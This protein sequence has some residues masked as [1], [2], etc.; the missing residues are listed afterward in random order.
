MRKCSRRILYLSDIVCEL[1]S[2]HTNLGKTHGHI[3]STISKNRTLVQWVDKICYKYICSYFIK[4]VRNNYHILFVRKSEK[5][6]F[7]NQLEFSKVK[8]L[9]EDGLT[10]MYP[11]FFSY[12][13]P[14]YCVHVRLCDRERK[15]SKILFLNWMISCSFRF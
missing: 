12:W 10:G 13:L 15:C 14:R 7:P 6:L 9:Q 4:L 11:R 5:S 2:T 8:I 1:R 3:D